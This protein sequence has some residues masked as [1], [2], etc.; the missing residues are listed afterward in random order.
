MISSSLLLGK[1]QPNEYIGMINK[2]GS[3]DYWDMVSCSI[4]WSYRSYKENALFHEKTSCLV[5]GIYCNI[6]KARTEYTKA[7]NSITLG[8][9]NLG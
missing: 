1:N 5:L 7:L 4:V 6:M 8:V 2:K 3:N 9:G